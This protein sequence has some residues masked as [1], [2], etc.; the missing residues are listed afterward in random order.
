MMLS[1]EFLNK[2]LNHNLFDFSKLMVF[3]PHQKVNAELSFDYPGC[4]TRIWLQFGSHL[5]AGAALGMEIGP[6]SGGVKTVLGADPS[7]CK[8]KVN[9][10]R[11]FNLV[12]FYDKI[13]LLT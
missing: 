1:L 13:C 10:S 6:L 9:V 3:L 5:D 2:Y 8:Q 12:V 7:G 4:V 11:Q